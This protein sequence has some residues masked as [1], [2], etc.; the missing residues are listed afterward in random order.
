VAGRDLP[1]CHVLRAEDIRLIEWPGEAVPPGF[2]GTTAELVGRGLLASVRVN[3]ALLE[4]KVASRDSGGGLPI[5]IPEG[6][7]AVSVKVDEVVGV[8]GFVLAGTRVDV[9]VP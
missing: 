8:A 4:T 9:V 5:I 6:M 2:V 7:R 1:V 3:E